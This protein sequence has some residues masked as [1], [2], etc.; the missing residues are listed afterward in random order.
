[1]P[2]Y[3]SQDPLFALLAVTGLHIRHRV[4][5]VPD[6]QVSKKRVHGPSK[7]ASQHPRQQE[8]SI[9]TLSVGLSE[10]RL[11]RTMH[12]LRQAVLDLLERRVFCD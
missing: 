4:T 1:M 11:S 8:S 9:Q 7:M 6:V 10:L 2:C 3:E 5:V 12:L